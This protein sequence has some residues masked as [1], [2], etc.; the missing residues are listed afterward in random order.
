MKTFMTDV[1]HNPSQESPE[2]AS[3]ATTTIG[4]E[5]KNPAAS[6]DKMTVVKIKAKPNEKAEDEVVQREE[7]ILRC[8]ETAVI[9]YLSRQ[10]GDDINL[11]KTL[12]R[13]EDRE[14]MLDRKLAMMDNLKGKLERKP[15]MLTRDELHE[16]VEEQKKMENDY[17]KKVEKQLAPI[18]EN[19]ILFHDYQN[20]I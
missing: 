13:L 11:T 16:V 1:K 12:K 18:F 19:R 5:V 4:S 14:R 10:I 7:R 3:M 15:C 9:F 17:R 20:L 8:I 6:P 2:K